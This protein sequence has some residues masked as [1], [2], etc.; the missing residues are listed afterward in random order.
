MHSLQSSGNLISFL[1]AKLNSLLC[2]IQPLK[3][4]SLTTVLN[5]TV[6]CGRK[7]KTPSETHLNIG[8]VCQPP[9]RQETEFR[10]WY[11]VNYSPNNDKK[12]QSG[13]HNKY[14]QIL[15][16]D[17]DSQAKCGH[18]KLTALFKT[19]YNILLTLEL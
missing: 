3:H 15:D 1:F 2:R 17:L 11:W 6:L 8:R 7:L 12:L 13:L 4:P 19:L 14:S 5:C 9:H 16:I 10:T 18:I